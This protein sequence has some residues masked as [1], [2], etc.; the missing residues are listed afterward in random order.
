MKH[1]RSIIALVLIGAL[2]FAAPAAWADRTA[3]KGRKI[4]A[5]FKEAVLTV[6]VVIKIKFQSS[7]QEYRME[8]TGTVINP[9]GLTVV[10]LSSID[11]TSVMRSVGP[12]RQTQTESEVTGLTLLLADGA[13]VPAKI[14]L[15]D[16]DLDLAYLRPIEK[17]AKPMPY[18]DLKKDAKVRLLDTVVTITRLGKV[19]NR[20]YSAAF[21]R[22]EA[23]VEKP[24]R[25]YI[26]GDDP[27]HTAQG[28]PAFTL[29]GKIVGV[30]VLRAIRNTGGGPG[31]DNVAVILLPA[32]DIL[33]GAEQAPGFDE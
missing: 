23:V 7:E 18:I 31:Q 30:F 2:L 12:R 6:Q 8:T 28:A 10:A 14:V 11:P 33:E 5:E 32:Q 4:A 24:R 26:P 29:D 20:V 1:T 19:A 27:T 25:F 3:D 13:E 15:R 9:E 17:P 16:V 22:I 21:E